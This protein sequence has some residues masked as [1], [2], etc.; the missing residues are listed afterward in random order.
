MLAAQFLLCLFYY[1]LSFLSHLDCFGL[2]RGAPLLVF[3]LE[4]VF[5]IHNSAWQQA[6]I[7]AFV[8]LDWTAGLGV[9]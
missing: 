7:W 2:G 1:T 9:G 6:L 5:L 4:A 3:P 8:G